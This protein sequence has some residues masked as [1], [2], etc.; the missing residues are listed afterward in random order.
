MKSL[1][2][3]LLSLCVAIGCTPK[4]TDTGGTTGATTGA[5]TTT[6]D[7]QPTTA[8]D[9]VPEQVV[10]PA[11]IPASVKHV[12]FDYYGLGN[13][14]AMDLVLRTPG[15]PA[16]TGGVVAQLEKVEGGK[17]FFKIVRT[18]ALAQDLGD[19]SVMVDSTGVY[20]VGTSIGTITPTKFLALPADLA[21]GK[22]W[23]LKTKVVRQDGQEIQEDSVYKVEGVRDLQT[24]GGTQKALLV[25]SNGTAI[26]SK[27]GKKDT[28]KYQ[29]KSWYVKGLGPVKIEISLT[30]P[31]QPTQTLTVEQSS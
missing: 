31:G 23:P 8:T 3:I 22:T 20:M 25:T 9:G 13:G 4:E 12:A 1:Y 24:K 21:P 27:D 17:A 30:S 2:L 26:V 6:G 15:Q 18:G 10:D 28:A 5:S 16:R 7:A 19:D 14:K 11:T 29:T